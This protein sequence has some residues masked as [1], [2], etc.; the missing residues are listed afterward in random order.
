M[1]AAPRIRGP[2]RLMLATALVIGAFGG[3]FVYGGWAQDSTATAARTEE[4][5]SVLVRAVNRLERQD[6][7]ALSGDVEARRSVDLGFMVAGRVA[8]VGADEGD[9]VRRGQPLAQLDSVDYALNLELATA[10]R[11]RAEDEF[12]RAQAVFAQKGISPNE[13]HRAQTAVRQAR[14]QEELARRKL[15]EARLFS[16]LSGIVARRSIEV[17][18][19]VGPGVPVFTVVEIDVVRVRVGVPEAEVGRVTVGHPAQVTIPAL[20]NAPFEG[21]VRAVAVT[22]DP[23][24]RTYS[25]RIEV[26][27]PSRV[28]R[29]GMI[30]EVLVQG[31]GTVRA[32]TVPGEAIVRDPEGAT[33]VFVYDPGEGRV[34]GRRVQ[35]GSVYGREIEIG[36]GLEGDE[37][38]VIGGQHRV[39][40]GSRVTARTVELPSPAER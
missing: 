2:G 22:A 39:R 10:Q 6:Y 25:V 15:A 36:S 37:L 38:I 23:T 28:L 26:P 1:V 9:A 35:V 18:E 8:A 40:E 24:S 33:R 12:G 20:R 31:G 16:P 14:A 29:P 5:V 4:P 7:L 32:L 19:Q 17:G 30:A 21:I 34:Y 3:F 13:F 11:D 27:N